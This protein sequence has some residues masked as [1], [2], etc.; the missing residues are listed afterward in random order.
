MYSPRT[1]SNWPSIGSGCTVWCFL[2]CD[3][4]L[5]TWMVFMPEFCSLRQLSTQTWSR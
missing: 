3:A 1:R 2:F 5:I 4:S